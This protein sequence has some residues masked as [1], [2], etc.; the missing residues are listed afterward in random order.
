[1]TASAS[2]LILMHIHITSDNCAPRLLSLQ[3]PEEA[4]DRIS[5]LCKTLFNVSTASA[6]GTT[7][8]AGAAACC[9]SCSS[10]ALGA[11]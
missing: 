1:M 4:Y 2:A 3:E 11:L 10:S 7:P 9:S 8:G 5:A 6:R